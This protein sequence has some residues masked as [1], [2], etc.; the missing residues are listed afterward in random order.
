MVTNNL[1]LYGIAQLFASTKSSQ[2]VEDFLTA[3][4]GLHHRYLHLKLS[5]SEIAKDV[6]ISILEEG[7]YYLSALA[8][9]P[10]RRE[11]FTYQ[12]TSEALGV[13]ALIFEYLG[14]LAKFDT[15]LSQDLESHEIYFLDACICNSLSIYEANSMAIARRQLLSNKKLTEIIRNFEPN[16]TLS[17]CYSV[18][19]TW[20]SRDFKSIWVNFNQLTEIYANTL[21]DINIQY[22]EERVSSKSIGELKL[23]VNLAFSVTYH[24]RY[25]EKGEAN[26]I[27]IANEK[28]NYCINLSERQRIPSTYWTINAIS[29]CSEKMHRNS[30]WN[31]L[32]GIVPGIYLR[33]LVLSKRPTFELWQSQVLALEIGKDQQIVNG[34]LNPA[35]KR[36]LI[37][38]PTSAG[39][40]LLAELAI[41]KSLFPDV[42][43]PKPLND[44]TCIYVVPSI[45]LVSEVEQKLNEKLLP[46]NIRT[47]A[48]LGGYDTAFFDEQK[49]TQTRVAILTPEKLSLLLRQKHPF[50]D[51]CKL[52]IFDEVHKVDSLD[53]G[54]TLEESITI[55]KDFD[56]NTMQSKMIF[57]SAIVSNRL[58]LE[59]WLQCEQDADAIVPILSIADS[60]QPTRQLKSVLLFDSSE[61]K[62]TESRSPKGRLIKSYEIP[63]HLIYVHDRLDIGSPNII[64]NIITTNQVFRE[65]EKRD[66]R[67]KFEK[68]KSSFSLTQN[69][70]L[71]TI[72]YLNAKFDPLLVYFM[73]RN[74]TQ[75]FCEDLYKMLPESLIT[76]P[77]IARKSFEELCNYI[78]YRLGSIPLIKYLRFG[79][80]YHHGQLPKDIRGELEDAYRNEW[81]RVLACTT[82]LT[83][84][85]NFPVK[86]LILA[87]HKIRIGADNS[88]Y[89]YLE[90]KDFRNMMGR[91]GRAVF[92][93]EGQIVFI[94][95]INGD[96]SVSLCDS[97]L[98]PK[99]TDK[100]QSVSSAFGREDFS[101]SIFE[102][103]LSALE[104]ERVDSN[105]SILDIDPASYPN[106]SDR[107]SA[108]LFLRLQAFLLTLMDR[109][110]LIPENMESFLFFFRRSLFGQ[111]ADVILQELVIN[112]CAAATNQI[113][114]QEPDSTKRSV[115]AKT[116]LSFASA[117][118]VYSFAVAFWGGIRNTKI[119]DFVWDWETIRNLGYQICLIVEAKPKPIK[120]P[121]KTITALDGSI[122]ADWIV[123]QSPL[124][125]LSEK[126]FSSIEDIGERANVCSSYI[127]DTFEYK[128]PWA[129]SAFCLFVKYLAD[130]DK[131][132]QF[133]TS[134]LSFELSMLP[135]Y[136]KFG[137]NSPAAAFFSSLGIRS[138]E[139]A[140]LLSDLFLEEFPSSESDFQLMFDWLFD[141]TPDQISE[142]YLT[143][144]EDD[145][146]GQVER[147]FKVISSL[148][149]K[150]LDF[151]ENL[152]LEIQ[153]SGWCY[154][155]EQLFMRTLLENQRL[156]L[157]SEPENKFDNNAIQ[158][159]TME[160]EKLG[161]IPRKF[162][163]ALLYLI[164][165]GDDLVCEFLR[166]DY[167]ETHRNDNFLIKISMNQS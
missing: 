123:Y 68:D 26:F 86:S 133:E 49:L 162:S 3:I 77:N 143:R 87:N 21:R 105:S 76:L 55:L 46:L 18:L 118:I 50:I 109:E 132:V 89:R 145:R 160:N 7:A 113:I 53:R 88:S 158:I 93:T 47:T 14:D 101:V 127:Q 111:S 107:S 139:M 60:W 153:I 79:V 167:L 72:K 148:E 149:S 165:S 36:V 24:S 124:K 74:E 12:Q 112:V 78:E 34:Y 152:P 2:Q 117:R 97:Y 129:I 120:F 116:G 156:L 69:A 91:V 30:V 11:E 119:E 164:E 146:S 154:Y 39:K 115:Y 151:R 85:V 102:Q 157:V 82:T 35:V 51:R 144:Y 161:Y 44:I 138:R 94:L 56:T 4:K 73:K 64:K 84:G 142:F 16:K 99:D 8:T 63:G 45:A 41:I 17:L 1:N 137:V 100:D 28:F 140:I 52:F 70:A 163:T 13:A 31:R 43:K 59:A 81:I 126:Y 62:E 110:I 150:E 134:K 25:F 42:N 90:K 98:F 114:S 159:F 5:P 20:I 23:W 103:I 19:Y 65:V 125:E 15:T 10:S 9:T 67:T 96:D 54:W 61:R 136:T 141:L 58:T 33:R 155:Q 92:D 40:S 37:S 121:K 106:D 29:L 166:Y 6:D 128:A 83:D 131:N 95:P 38:M 32:G 71:V 22:K 57:M 66:G 27:K 147:L 75:Q 48:V 122:L 104:E 135:A 80:A 108:N 130:I